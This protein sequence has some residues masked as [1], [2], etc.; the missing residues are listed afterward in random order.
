MSEIK[1]VIFDLGGVVVRWEPLSV[2]RSFKGDRS[3]LEYV[4]KNGF[5]SGYWREFDRGMM[6]QAELV[7][8]TADAIGCSEESCEAFVT[9]IMHSLGPMEETEA[10][11]RELSARGFKLYCLSNM[12]VEFYDYLKTREVFR[13]FDGQIISALEHLVKPDPAIYNLL[14]GRFGL[15]AEECLFID[16]LEAN[17]EAAERLGIQG[18][19]FAPCRRTYDL[20]REKLR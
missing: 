5:F 10:L 20:I 8:L 14:L 13:Y 4:R 7:R 9:H 16:D 2:L 12:S 18:V 17:V 19:H 3:I 6:S 11:I 1:N 15:R